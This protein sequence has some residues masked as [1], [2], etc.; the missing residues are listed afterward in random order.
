MRYK[1]KVYA[2]IIWMITALI[3]VSVGGY[4]GVDYL[5]HIDSS[6]S[7]TNPESSSSNDSSSSESSSSSSESSSSESSSSSIYTGLG[8]QSNPLYINDTSDDNLYLYSQEMV[9]EY[10]DSTLL[11]YGNFE[12]LIDGGQ[13]NDANN[14][15]NMLESKC[16]DGVLEMLIA[17]HG[18]SDHVGG[19]NSVG[20]SS[21]SDINYIIDYGYVYSSS[22]HSNYASRRA[23]YVNRGAEYHPITDVMAN[24]GNG[25][26]KYYITSSLSIEFLETECYTSQ[27][28]DDPNETSIAM[29]IS[30]NN[31]KY[32]IAGDLTGTPEQNIVNNYR[33]SNL[34]DDDDVV[35]YKASHHGSTSNSSNSTRILSFL[36]PDYCFISA[37]IT[38]PNTSSSYTQWSPQHPYSNAVTF[39]RNYTGN[40]IFWNG[41]MGSISICS[42]G[43]TLTS[44]NG[45]GRTR[46]YYTGSGLLVDPASE[47]DANLFSTVWYQQSRLA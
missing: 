13:G 40:N 46:N 19:L 1:R 38:D 22:A 6:S 21:I 24:D 33:D 42:D 2:K 3:I 45:A 10:G 28:P 31:V 43:N 30:Y 47:K 14:V 12:I 41:T 7:S 37:A 32:Y 11:K 9:S 5:W 8:S 36:D 15:H 20:L 26:P 17:T 39:I 25:L 27:T 18:H 34:V 29:L 35:I 44:I 4:F 23:Y 16:T